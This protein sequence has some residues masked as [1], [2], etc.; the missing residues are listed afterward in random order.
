MAVYVLLSFKDDEQAKTFVANTLQTDEVFLY[1]QEEYVPAEVLGVFK[2]P[3]A[4]CDQTNGH[5]KKLTGWTRGRNYGWWICASCGKPSK[6]W[7][8]GG[9]W[10]AL[11][12]NLLPDALVDE[13]IHRIKGWD[14]PQ[15]WKFLLE[16]FG[17]D[18]VDVQE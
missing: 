2:K 17:E 7:A 15:E 4:F 10:S 14:S 12:T 13:P 3:T 16:V 11:G 5:R 6:E 8:K 1:A 9:Q 18:K